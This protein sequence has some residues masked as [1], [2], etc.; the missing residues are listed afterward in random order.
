MASVERL[1]GGYAPPL[2]YGL[3]A[4]FS[5]PTFGAVI[6]GERGLG[7]VLDVF[8]LPRT[9]ILDAWPQ[10]GLTLWNPYLT[11][12][13]ALLAQQA[14][15]PFAID[16]A[17]GLIAGPFAGYL[18][19][20]W[21]VAAFGGLSMHLF[22]RDSVGLSTPAVVGG[23]VIFLFG[24]WIFI[25]GASGV[26]L[27]LILWLG[28]RAMIRATGRWRFILGGAVAGAVLLY[29]GQ[30]QI[31]LIAAGVQL[32]YLL[33]T[34]P[35]GGRGERLGVWI[36]TWALAVGMYG[37]VLFT[38]LVMLPISQRTVWDLRALYDP[39][40]LEAIRDTL[41][42]YS[43]TLF[44]V[45]L[46]GGIG[47]SPARYGTYF[48][49]AIGLPLLVIGLAWGRRTARTRFLIL[50]LVAIPVIDLVGL[51]LTPLQDQLGFLKSF[52][53]VRI[54]QLF[55]FALAA[56][57]AVGL[58][59]A[60]GWWTGERERPRRTDWRWVVLTAAL[61][62]LA[63]AVVV[64][65]G[66]V[67]RRRRDL[68]GLE[69]PALGWALLLLALLV[70][71]AVL[72][73]A[74][75]ALWRTRGGNDRARGGALVVLAG[76]FLFLLAGER[77]VY[78]HGERFVGP[79]IEGWA[80]NLGLTPGQAF[81]LEQPGADRDRVLSFG[82]NPN[83]MGAVGLLQADGNQ[84]IYPVTYHDLF[85]ALIRP[86]LDMDPAAATYFDD[87]GNRAMTFGPN[88]DP[89][90]VA[91]VGA[92]WLYVRGE[93]VPT[94]PDAVPRFRDG[95]VTVYEVPSVLPRAF[96]AGAVSIQ[97][98]PDQVLGAL[99]AADLATLRGTA[100][101]VEGADA[102]VLGAVPRATGAEARDA[103]I[104]SMT[105]DR[106]EIDVRTDG[107]AVL[108][109]TDVAAPGWIAE[110]DG[111]EVPIAT[112]DRAFRGVAVDGS[113][114]R[115]VFRYVPVFTY[116]GFVAAGVAL[117]AALVWAWLVRRSDGRRATASSTLSP[118][119]LDSGDPTVEDR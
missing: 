44:G 56:N 107:P 5:F 35:A 59:V 105:P 93:E 30:S 102:D 47:A 65:A 71:S 84:A 57:A 52:Q 112:V 97:P 58:D 95:E 115:V 100:F 89:E 66:Q 38:Q 103:T 15:P 50:L 22:L 76:L 73:T 99:A 27:P 88:V 60:V 49:G 11:A 108:V 118:A 1:R 34:S 92:R 17:V 69:T 67:L 45:P 6:A 33:L 39:R 14:D 87:W 110:R 19:M 70:G 37:P 4:L 29:H 25:N 24:F 18:V 8:E 94:V 78:A 2:L 119:P 82:E 61:V 85:G 41:A 23:S 64:A 81:I 20:G 75:A 117:L 40:P 54:R 96:V 68:V 63:V 9:G 109:L 83:R 106:V 53:V 111:A 80:A 42:H 51:L 116:L 55:T 46:G 98:G 10:Y 101:V 74:A 12:G 28:D 62:P 104:L 43:A 79:Y 21:L 90:L 72:V 91:L 32:A 77:A 114:S 48:L 16:V 113:T 3:L 7:Y 36:A 13:N 26:A 86:Q 31:V